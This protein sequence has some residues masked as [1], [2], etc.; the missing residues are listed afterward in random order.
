MPDWRKLVENNLSRLQLPA[1]E[2][3]EVWTELTHHLEDSYQRLVNTGVNQEDAVHQVEASVS[4]WESLAISVVHERKG[5]MSMFG[6][7]FILPSG[8]AF[9]VATFTLALEI[10]FG[11][12]PAVWN[13]NSAQIVV[14]KL[15]PMALLITG[16]LTAFLC[17]RFGA[18]RRRRLLVAMTP[19]LYMLGVMLFVLAVA[20]PLH[21]L[22]SVEPNPRLFG[23]SFLIAIANWV[24]LPAISLSLG[25]LPFLRELPQAAKPVA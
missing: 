7:Q 1:A 9:G 2:R 6:K 15:W 19:S 11:P 5:N 18:S 13:F 22:R 14:Y 21:Y 8:I 20:F 16:A 10:R 23:W 25:A 24:V 3:D 17:L 4:D 12:R